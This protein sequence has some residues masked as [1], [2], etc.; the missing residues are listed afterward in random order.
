MNPTAN[1]V[2]I[3]LPT[4]YTTYLVTQRSKSSL[5]PCQIRSAPHQGCRALQLHA[6]SC[7]MRRIVHPWKSQHQD[8]H[9]I[10]YTVFMGKTFCESSKKLPAWNVQFSLSC[11]SVVC[12]LHINTCSTQVFRV[13]ANSWNIQKFQCIMNGTL[14]HLYCISS[15]PRPNFLWVALP[16]GNNWLG[17]EIVANSCR[18]STLSIVTV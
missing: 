5:Q 14:Q 1:I 6:H 4:V 2:K 15:I 8:Y 17:I 16:H 10:W 9:C 18:F 7:K 13:Q 11:N 3:S 12:A